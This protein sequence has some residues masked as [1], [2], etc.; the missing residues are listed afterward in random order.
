MKLEGGVLDFVHRE[1]ELETLPAEIP[2]AIEVDVTQPRPQR[3]D[4]RARRRDQRQVDAGQRSRHDARARRSCRARSKSRWRRRRRPRRRRPRAAEPEVIKK[5]KTDKEGEAPRRQEGQGRTR[6]RR[7]A[8]SSASAIRGRSIATPAHNVG[9]W[10]DRRDRRAA[11]GVRDEW[12]ERT[13]CACGVK[14]GRADAIL[15]LKPLTF[16][17]LSGFAV[18][19]AA[20]YFQI[21]P[22]RHPRRR[23]RSGAA[24]RAAAGAARAAA[25]AGTTG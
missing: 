9:F 20:Q 16:M 8:A 17:N 21:E 15:L 12:R 23:R 2:D 5:G 11:G 3:R 24:A 10:V 22:R 4:L 25:P 7:E 6:S 1:I 19:Q 13:G 18:S 14:K